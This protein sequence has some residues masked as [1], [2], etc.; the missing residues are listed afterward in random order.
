MKK[1][2]IALAFLVATSCATFAAIPTTAEGW[3]TPTDGFAKCSGKANFRYSSGKS[4]ESGWVTTDGNGNLDYSAMDDHWGTAVIPKTL[5]QAIYKIALNNELSQKNEKRIE[6]LGK[7]LNE[8]LGI[9]QISVS[10][11]SPGGT[12]YTQTSSFSGGLA[13]AING[14]TLYL[15][16]SRQDAN[17]ADE[18]T[19]TWTKGNKIA[20]VNADQAR[21]TMGNMTDYSDYA[22][23]FLG[24]NGRLGWAGFG[25]FDNRIFAGSKSRGTTF[26]EVTFYNWDAPDTTA[27]A[28]SHLSVSGQLSLPDGEDSGYRVLVRSKD[29]IGIVYFPFGNLAGGAACDDVSVTTNAANG[30]VEA[31]KASVYGFAKAKNYDLPLKVDGEVAWKSLEDVADGK[32]LGATVEG[33]GI[34]LQVKGADLYAG[35][36]KNHYFG[37]SQGEGAELGWWELPNVTTNMV[38]GDE[39]T[40]VAGVQ[41]PGATFADGTKAVGLLGWNYNYKAT[42]PLV[43]INDHGWLSYIGAD[44]LAGTNTCACP[45]KWENLLDWTECGEVQEVSEVAEG[46][47]TNTVEKIVFPDG[48]GSMTAFLKNRNFMYVAADT[49]A[50]GAVSGEWSVGKDGVTAPTAAPSNWT[51]GKALGLTDDGK[52]QIEGFDTANAKSACEEEIA[53]QLAN[54]LNS[55]LFLAKHEKTG[56]LHYVHAGCLTNLAASVDGV[57]IATNEYS[58][59]GQIA[60]KGAYELGNAGKAIFSTGSGIEWKS[61]GAGVKV[62]GTDG[63]TNW[64]GVESGTNVPAQVITFASATNSNV[65]VWVTG[66][67]SDATV[68]IGVYYK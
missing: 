27:S 1:P 2:C 46:G 41:P 68:T 61:I 25:G 26:K 6:T 19:T 15:S 39:R 45:L 28:D 30:A 11:T 13:N 37:T 3:Y 65:K 67:K 10:G 20:L 55:H 22:L 36:V 47:A 18:K 7:N 66:T 21:S 60:I 43:L 4:L 51:D 49:N 29:G 38:V 8:L 16:N 57:T 31:G 40:V 53:T 50:T 9:S 58:H 52:F 48:S 34:A 63:S 14:G 17:I 64:S 44:K 42:T 62:V 33:D 35:R 12:A 5:Q 24:D 23:A 59:A 56:E 54:G 32:S